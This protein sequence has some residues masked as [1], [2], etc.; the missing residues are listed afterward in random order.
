MVVQ[1]NQRIQPLFSGRLQA[2]FEP[3]KLGAAEVA[4]DLAGELGVQQDKLPGADADL[5]RQP[6][7]S[8]DFKHR[9]AQ[10]VVAG[11]PVVL[12]GERIEVAYSASIRVAGP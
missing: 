10:I 2:G 1:A 12:G 9:L 11:Q 3:L 6:L 8:A 4:A 7:R 5:P